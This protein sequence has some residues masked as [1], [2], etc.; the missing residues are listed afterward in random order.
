MAVRINSP[1]FNTFKVD[2]PIR[3]YPVLMDTSIERGDL[4]YF[5]T[6]NNVRYV[7]NDISL[8][9]S[10]E[11]AHAIALKEASYPNSVECYML[12]YQQTY[13][14]LKA[15]TL[16]KLANFSYNELSKVDLSRKIK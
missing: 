1:V 13:D 5:Y 15:F 14:E 11:L 4:L 12:Q 10:Y 2:A 9:D 16:D 7:T 6:V 8:D 3:T